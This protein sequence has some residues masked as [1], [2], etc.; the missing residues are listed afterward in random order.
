MLGQTHVKLG[1]GADAEKELMRA[2]D[3]GADPQAVQIALADAWLL[4]GEKTGDRAVGSSNLTQP[5]QRFKN[6]TILRDAHAD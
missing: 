3:L 5:H 1:S 2:R 4:Q 6:R